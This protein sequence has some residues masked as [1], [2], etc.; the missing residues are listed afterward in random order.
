MTAVAM[1]PRST[2]GRLRCCWVRDRGVSEGGGVSL[3]HAAILL[4]PLLSGVGV[5]RR[6]DLVCERTALSAARWQPRGAGA[7]RRRRAGGR[8]VDG[9]PV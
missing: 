3:R 9:A 2:S 5:A 8:V 4:A 6:R 7:R 1:L